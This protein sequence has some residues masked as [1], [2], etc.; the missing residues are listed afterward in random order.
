MAALKRKI[1]RE[2]NDASCPFAFSAAGLRD[3]FP[4]WELGRRP[5]RHDL[6]QKWNPGVEE[7]ATPRASETT[8]QN[9]VGQ[10]PHRGRVSNNPDHC[11]PLLHRDHAASQ[12][13]RGH[14]YAWLDLYYDR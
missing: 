9:F 1:C 13:F 2:G 3:R 14:L 12:Q 6:A 7:L 4:L 10:R 8:S 5:Y 11:I